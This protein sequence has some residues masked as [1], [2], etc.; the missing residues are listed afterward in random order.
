MSLETI[1]Y[2]FFTH[3]A[4]KKFKHLLTEAAIV[5]TE[6]TEPIQQ[7]LVLQIILPDDSAIN[8]QLEGWYDELSSQEQTALEQDMFGSKALA[9][10]YLQLANGQQTIA[11]VDPEVLKRILTVVSWDELNI[12]LDVIVHSVE[13]PEL[14]PLC[15]C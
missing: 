4:A 6:Q 5:Y 8:E 1:E 15:Q 7:A 14:T 3:E 2:V 11:S 10:L 9:G 12:F 13:N